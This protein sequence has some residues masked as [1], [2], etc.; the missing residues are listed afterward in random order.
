[1]AGIARILSDRPRG[2]LILTPMLRFL[3]RADRRALRFMRA[4]GHS[5]AAE[6]VMKALGTT[7]E[8]GVVWVAIAL[9]AAAS[10]PKRRPRWLRAAPVAPTA[11]GLN[12]LVKVAV[13]R[14]RPRLRRLPALASAPSA[15]SFPSAHAT[16]SLAAATAMGRVEPRARLPL[17]ALAAA[18]CATRPYLGMHYPSDVLAGAALGVAI[19]ASWPG[20]RGPGTE[21]RLIDLVIARAAAVREAGPGPNGD[22]PDR[23]P[24]GGDAPRAQPD[25]Q[26][27]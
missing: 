11:V 17:F 5:P 13:R 1:V 7:G 19:G 26:A 12:Y 22:R 6:G 15:L 10:D 25:P 24:S 4:R 8:W 23:E 27:Q 21:D 2:G 18:L 9:A 3:E 16:S 14:D 20:L